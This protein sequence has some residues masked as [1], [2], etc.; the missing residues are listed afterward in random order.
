MDR[1]YATLLAQIEAFSVFVGEKQDVAVCFPGMGNRLFLLKLVD[2]FNAHMVIFHGELEGG[3]QARVLF[4]NNSFPL[5]LV[6]TPTVEGVAKR[7]I[8]FRPAPT[9]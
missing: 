2:E 5:V 1:L 8:E 3:G 6:A 4:D 7:T 9:S